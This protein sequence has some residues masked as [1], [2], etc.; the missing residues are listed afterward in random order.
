MAGIRDQ[1]ETCLGSGEPAPRRHPIYGE[2][3]LAVVARLAA[4]VEWNE[5][6]DAGAIS[7]RPVTGFG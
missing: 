6:F 7:V 4:G 1:R 2:V 3:P 5:F